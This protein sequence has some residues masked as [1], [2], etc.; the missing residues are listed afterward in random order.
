MKLTEVAAI[1]KIKARF[2]AVSLNPDSFCPEILYHYTS[3]SGLLGI[4]ES[5]I[6]RG[7]NYSFLN[8]SNEIRYGQCLIQEII[9]GYITSNPSFSKHFHKL[10]D[11]LS[12]AFDYYLTCFCS[13][14]NLLSQWRGYG[15]N[16]GCYCIGFDIEQMEFPELCLFSKVIY[17]KDEQM[18]IIKQRIDTVLEF[19]ITVNVNHHDKIYDLLLLRLIKDTCLFKHSG[20]AEEREWRAVVFGH[21]NDNIQ[22]ETSNGILKPYIELV[23]GGLHEDG[24]RRLPIKEIV[25]GPAT[26]IKAVNLLMTKYGYEDVSVRESGIPYRES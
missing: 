25:V 10:F 22:F 18:N 7:S 21:N 2:N 11:W 16:N 3:A 15:L 20:F 8:D 17:N 1:K 6:L 14:S 23:T 24:H 4:I 19:F 13:E 26:S 5:G 9:K 12:N